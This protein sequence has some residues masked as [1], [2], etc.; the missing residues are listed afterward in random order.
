[1]GRVRKLVGG[2]EAKMDGLFDMFRAGCQGS[3]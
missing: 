3:V 1:V 2:V